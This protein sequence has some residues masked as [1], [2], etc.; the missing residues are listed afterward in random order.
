MKSDIISRRDEQLTIS[1]V[2]SHTEGRTKTE[3]VRE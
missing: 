1:T 2:V 3:G